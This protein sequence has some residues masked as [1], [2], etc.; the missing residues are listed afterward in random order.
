MH[1]SSLFISKPHFSFIWWLGQREDALSVAGHMSRGSKK[2]VARHVTPSQRR[3]T[4]PGSS[5]LDSSWRSSGCIIG[6][7]LAA[8]INRQCLDRWAK[9]L[10]DWPRTQ[11]GTAKGIIRLLPPEK[12]LFME[13]KI[14]GD[15]QL[16]PKVLHGCCWRI[17]TCRC[18]AFSRQDSPDSSCP[19]AP[20]DR[21]RNGFSCPRDGAR[22]VTQAL[23][24]RKWKRDLV[25]GGYF[26][27]SPSRSWGNLDTNRESTIS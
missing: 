11:H 25:P 18:L 2:T 17:C 23:T 20:L 14:L 1:E 10:H 24:A 27:V 8:V 21:A 19:W 13:D 6:F 26:S 12:T 9:V 7:F 3:M 4:A 16:I 5:A 15:Q 22:R